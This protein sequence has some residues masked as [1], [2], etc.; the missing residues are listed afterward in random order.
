MNFVKTGRNLLFVSL[1]ALALAFSQGPSFAKDKDDDRPARSIF[2]AAEYPGV[3]VPV[4]E[5]VS[6]DIIFNNKGKSDE[7]MSVWIAEKPEGWTAKIKTYRFSVT[8]IHVP[9]GDDKTLTFEATPGKEVQPGK[10]NFRIEAQT[11]DGKFKMD[12]NISVTVTGAEE[13]SEEDRG[14][15]LTTS[16]PVIRGAVGCD[17]RVFG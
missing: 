6:M 12:Q 7:N 3:E 8:G 15:K 17:L 4:E 10:Y 16:Y 2:M 9:G 11:E 5:N 14:V 13:K 1:M